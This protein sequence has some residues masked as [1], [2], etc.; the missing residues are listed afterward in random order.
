MYK[1]YYL[2]IKHLLESF[3]NKEEDSLTEK[4]YCLALME[5]KHEYQL[6][7]ERKDIEISLFNT[8]LEEQVTHKQSKGNRNNVIN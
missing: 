4:E 3:F 8:W 6:Q 7:T 5:A 2:K 1:E